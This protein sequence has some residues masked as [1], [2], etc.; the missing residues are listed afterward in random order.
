MSTLAIASQGRLLTVDEKLAKAL[1]GDFPVTW[2]H[3]ENH[4]AA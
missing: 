3:S 2:E 4:R 1:S